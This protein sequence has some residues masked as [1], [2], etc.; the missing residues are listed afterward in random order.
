M[1]LHRTPTIIAIGGNGGFSAKPH[2]PSLVPYCLEQTGKNNPKV[3]FVPTASGDSEDYI[4]RFD[5]AFSQYACDRSIVTFFRQP[6]SRT[7]SLN[8]LEAQLLQQDLIYVGGGNTRAM[9]TVWRNW[10]LPE[11][12]RRVWESGVVL[13]G[14]SAGALCWFDTGGS[15]ST[16]VG[17][18]SPLPG[19]G[20]LPGSCTPHY[21]NQPNRRPDVHQLMKNGELPQGIGIDDGVA[22]R[23]NGT[24]I[25]EAVRS[26]PEA[27]AYFLSLTENNSIT[28]A[29]M[30][31]KTIS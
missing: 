23:F 29:C 21:S 8:A 17:A 27:K 2:E 25:A 10:N 16:Y 18:L 9:L 14:V 24:E 6:T 4:K 20:L 7:L 19:I 5:A 31:L 12:F 1:S 15:D 11:I 26:R 30:E 22:V 3:C 28:E 13:A